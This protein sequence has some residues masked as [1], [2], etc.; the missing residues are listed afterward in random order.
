MWCCTRNGCLT[1]KR[2]SA[3]DSRIPAEKLDPL[4][5]YSATRIKNER[6]EAS[7]D[8]FRQVLVPVVATAIVASALIALSLAVL[9][10]RKRRT[11]HQKEELK[12]QVRVS[13]LLWGIFHHN[14]AFGGFNPAQPS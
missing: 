13:S 4:S 14:P 6:V 7:K 11:A 5:C 3:P 9:C 1:Y 12:Q 8:Q 2:G 10:H